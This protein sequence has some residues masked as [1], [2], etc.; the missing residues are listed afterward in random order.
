[1]STDEAKAL[2]AWRGAARSAQAVLVAAVM[3]CEGPSEV[4]FYS[5]LAGLRGLE[6]KIEGQLAADSASAF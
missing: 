5:I 2:L 1:M 6:S 3:L 4:G